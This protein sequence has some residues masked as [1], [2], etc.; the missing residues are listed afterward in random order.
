MAT[1]NEKPKVSDLILRKKN[2][3]EKIQSHPKDR[4][5]PYVGEEPNRRKVLQL[6]AYI[7]P[8]NYDYDWKRLSSTYPQLKNFEPMQQKAQV[9]GKMFHRLLIYSEK[10]NLRDLCNYLR[11]NHED[12]FL[13]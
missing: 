12:C 5:A 6:G 11:K 4:Y 9:H 10:A 2:S 7:Y 3:M 13:R 8:K 1:Q